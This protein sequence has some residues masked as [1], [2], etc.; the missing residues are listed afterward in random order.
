MKLLTIVLAAPLLACA[1]DGLESPA[2]PGAGEAARSQA[3]AVV[4]PADPHES[5]HSQF[6]APKYLLPP[7]KIEIGAFFGGNV[8]SATS[9][10]NPSLG[11]EVVLGL[12]HGFGLLGEGTWNRILGL[13]A[14]GIEAKAALFDLGG[15]LQWSPFHRG[16]F[17]P[18][19]RGGLSWVRVGAGGQIGSM[20]LDRSTDRVGGNFGFG[21]RIYLAEH[22][23]VL[24]DFRAVQGPQAAWLGR[25]STGLFYR[26]K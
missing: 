1:Q 12:G 7:K 26:F 11:G 17:S 4:S 23:G 21:G 18:H 6:G 25:F 14:P 15:G 22:Y 20:K 5:T 8:F 24:L 19:L 10:A 2:A 3:V 13:K 9:Q 16:R